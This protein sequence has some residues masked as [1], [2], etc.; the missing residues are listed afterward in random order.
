MKK[1]WNRIGVKSFTLIELLVVIAIIG[2]L[3]GLLLPAV[4]AA[5]E[6][7]RRASC[8]SN[9]SQFGKALVMY[10]MDHS[11]KFPSHLKDLDE[12]IKQAKLFICPSDKNRN[13]TNAV[14]NVD[15]TKCSYCLVLKDTDGNAVTAA[16]D[17]SCMLA[18]DKD[19][20]KAIGEGKP[21]DQ[22]GHWGDNHDGKGGNILYLDGSVTWVNTGTASSDPDTW[23]GA[24]SDNSLSNIIGKASLASADLAED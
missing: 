16:T 2:I 3:A 11:E 10:S 22:T 9:L 20:G 13:P 1:I 4:A 24:I 15:G 23:E 17:A 18:C 19:G 5:R 7:A 12:F 8:M 21:T 6:K 14:G